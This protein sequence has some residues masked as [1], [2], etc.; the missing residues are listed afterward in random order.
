MKKNTYILISLFSCLLIIAY[1][2]LQKPGEQSASSASTGPVFKVDSLSVDKIEI[3][4]P[5]SSLVLEKRGVEWFLSK[6]VNYKA[7]QAHVGQIIHQIKN[8]EV[9]NIVSSKPEKHSVFQVD[10]TGTQVTVY[11]I[12][13]EKASFVLGKMAGSYSESYARSMNSDDVFIVEGASSYLFDRPVK[14]WRD[15][16]ILTA[17]KENIKDIRY[18]YGDTTF[19]VTFSDSAWF[20]GK[21]KVQQSVIEAVVS[22]LSNLQA[23]DFIDSTVSP[24]V[25]AMIA[26]AGA[27]I[28]F[29]FNKNVN[30]YYVQ[31]SNAPQWFVLDPGKANQILKRKK[32]FVETNI[33][34][35]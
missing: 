13:A 18:Q 10:Q 29:S 7:D 19:T 26:Y 8:L 31:S 25:T 32:D 20:A 35:K 15:K 6:P 27:Q 4:T 17:P 9:K 23:D 1:L 14:D 3:K 34:E 24:K 11:E 33:K 16:T 30:K 12:G 21:E 28:R 2:V 5:A 22:S